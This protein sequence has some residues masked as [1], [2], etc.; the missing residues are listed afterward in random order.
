MIGA[1]SSLNRG[2][3]EASDGLRAFFALYVMLNRA[4]TALNKQHEMKND[5]KKGITL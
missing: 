1:D 2:S 4:Q 5:M 3:P